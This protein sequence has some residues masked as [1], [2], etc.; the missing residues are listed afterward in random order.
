[1]EHQIVMNLEEAKEIIGQHFGVDRD[2]VHINLNPNELITV[3]LGSLSV[4][5]RIAVGEKK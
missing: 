3:D 5:Q 4:N 1:M 2:V